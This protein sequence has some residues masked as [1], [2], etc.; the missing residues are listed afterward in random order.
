MRLGATMHQHLNAVGAS[1]GEQVG[2]W[3]A[4]HR[5]RHHTGQRRIFHRPQVQRLGVVRYRASMRIN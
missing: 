5:D 3:G 4:P 1:M 2:R